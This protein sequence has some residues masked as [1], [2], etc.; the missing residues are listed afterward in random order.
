MANN[1]EAEL[2]PAFFIA[3]RNKGQNV[4]CI[5]DT[6]LFETSDGVTTK[7]EA[8]QALHREGWRW[9]NGVLCPGCARREGA[10]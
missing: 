5:R 10:N 8:V 3:C 6:I 2:T 1:L 9:L 4:D 7:E